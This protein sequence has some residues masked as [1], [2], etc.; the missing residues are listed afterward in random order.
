MKSEI[1][2]SVGKRI[3]TLQVGD[4]VYHEW[5]NGRVVVLIKSFMTGS[6][7]FNVLLLGKSG[8]CWPQ[9]HVGDIVTNVLPDGFVKFEGELKLYNG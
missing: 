1:I 8:M 4:L 5:V 3:P 6:C 2:T 9:F 7:C